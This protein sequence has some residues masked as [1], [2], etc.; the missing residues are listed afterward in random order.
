MVYL[1][2][3]QVCGKEYCG[4][5][6][7]TFADDHGGRCPDVV[8]CNRIGDPVS[9]EIFLRSCAGRFYHGDPAAFDHRKP[10]HAESWDHRNL[11]C[12]DL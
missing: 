7:C 6:V 12:K 9:G 4:F 11:H 1:V 8:F 5:F 3:D 10:D 2:S